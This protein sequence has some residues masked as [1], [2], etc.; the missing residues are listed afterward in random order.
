MDAEQDCVR[1][2]LRAYKKRYRSKMMWLLDSNC[3]NIIDPKEGDMWEIFLIR[4]VNKEDVLKLCAKRP[5]KS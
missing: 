5:A 4:K 1:T 2:T 3:E